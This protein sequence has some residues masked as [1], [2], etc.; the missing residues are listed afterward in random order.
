ML[1]RHRLYVSFVVYVPCLLSVFIS[2]PVC[3]RL[4]LFP[5][6]CVNVEALTFL[7]VVILPCVSCSCDEPCYCLTIARVARIL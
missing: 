2:Q 6:L 1:S 3:G 5:L 4:V 7:Y